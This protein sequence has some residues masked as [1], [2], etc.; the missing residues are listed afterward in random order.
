MGLTN[1][2]STFKRVMHTLLDKYLDQ[3]V[4]VYLDDVLIYSKD[5]DSHFEHLRLIVD[6]LKKHQFF[7]KLKKC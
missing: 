6:L 5:I 2:P 3:F 7:V 1:A 4:V